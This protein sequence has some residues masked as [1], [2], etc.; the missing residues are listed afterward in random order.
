MAECLPSPSMHQACSIHRATLNRCEGTQLRSQH[1]GG[2]E[3]Q[4]P[5]LLCTEFKATSCLDATT[6]VFLTLSPLDSAVGAGH[7]FFKHEAFGLLLGFNVFKWVPRICMLVRIHSRGR[8]LVLTLL[9]RPV[10][11]LAF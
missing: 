1:S 6:S 4:G 5:L 10:F 11:V 7:G 3:V 8:Y 9:G 2:P